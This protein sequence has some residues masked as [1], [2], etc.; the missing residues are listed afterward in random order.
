M[1]SVTLWWACLAA[2]A[3]LNSGLWVFARRRLAQRNDLPAE[4]RATRQ[5]V[6]WLSLGYVLGCAFRSLLPLVDAPRTCLLDVWISRVGISRSVATIAELCF[7]AQWALLLREAGRNTGDRFAMLAAQL[8]IPLIVL[9]EISCWTAVLSTNYFFHL[10]ENSLWTLTTAVIAAG[11]LSLRPR[12]AGGPQRCVTA[13]IAFALVYITFMLSFD[14]P[15]YFS[16]WR[17]DLAAGRQYLSLAEGMH[18]VLERCTVTFDW[19]RWRSEAAWMTPYFTFGVWV[20]IA[21]AHVPPLVRGP[22]GRQGGTDGPAN[23]IR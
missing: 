2:V 14:L 9:A 7:V 21:L 1:D 15:M 18:E 13:A 5:W 11:C 10:V 23:T 19:T 20:S 3:L 8:P 4:V 12:L 16:R 6:L 22:L 17:A